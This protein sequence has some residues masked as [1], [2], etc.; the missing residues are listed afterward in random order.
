[1][2]DLGEFMA[3]A[4][5]EGL[6]AIRERGRS[7][8]ARSARMQEIV[9]A[10]RSC[11]ARSGFHQTSIRDIAREA[12]IRSP[13]ILHYHFESKEQIFLE[14]VWDTCEEIAATA[15][16]AASGGGSTGVLDALDSLW[17]EIDARPEIT[18]LLVEFCSSAMRD[19]RSRQMM[20]DFLERMRAVI[21]DILD[22]SM[23]RA[24]HLL[25][26]QKDIMAAMVL[27]IVEGH[28]IHCA[29]QGPTALTRSQRR[30]LRALLTMLGEL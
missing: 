15:R 16:R 6:P 1:M 12:G 17:Q 7:G 27:N 9:A 24:V 20:A 10:A 26:M 21:V 5:L 13:S 2:G 8:D 19:E 14:V 28:A 22:E 3:T 18:P 25:P 29:I 23:G 4:D 11:F 30:Q